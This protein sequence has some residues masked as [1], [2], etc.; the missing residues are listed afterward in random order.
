[1]L[2]KRSL[3]TVAAAVAS[4]LVVSATA[5]AAAAPA[6]V[7]LGLF[8]ATGVPAGVNPQAVAGARAAVRALNAAGG[9]D[10]HPVQL[11][12][13]NHRN[14]PNLSL[15][16]ARKMVAEHVL[17]MIGGYAF[18]DATMIPILAKA[19]IPLVGF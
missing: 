14:D 10:G 5:A 6:P 19:H 8:A 9:L 4:A 7:K 11:V 2:P 1:M 18:N 13:C 15:A 16:C 3:V 17:A 12:F